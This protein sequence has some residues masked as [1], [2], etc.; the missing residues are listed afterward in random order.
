MEKPSKENQ[1]KKKN[2]RKK[3]SIPKKINGWKIAFLTLVAVLIGGT[4]FLGVRIF[5]PREDAADL[6]KPESLS[7]E[8]VLTVNTK[9]SQINKLMDHYLQDFQEGSDVQYEFY[10]ENEAL[11]T[12]EFELFSFPVQFYLYFDR[13]K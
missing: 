2:A 11:L 10:L 9:K 8:S 4:L 5:E 12:G 13:S 6:V 7:G 1:T 3:L